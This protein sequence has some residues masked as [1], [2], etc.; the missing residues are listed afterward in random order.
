VVTS[1]EPWARP[2]WVAQA[3]LLIESFAQV[4]GRDLVDPE[5]SPL[6]R[7]ERLYRAPFVVVSHGTEADPILSYGNAAA[8]AL[9]DMEAD[10]FIR[11]PSR[12]TAEPVHRAERERLL[13]RTLRD[14][15]VDDY[16]GVRISRN[17]KRFRIEQAVVWN[18]VDTSGVRRGQAATFARWTPVG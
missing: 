12:L 11:T 14:G 7:A 2:D 16:A 9:W 3:D 13:E 4:V 18:V 17:G 8:L 6:V 15:F 5:G 10:R 1:P